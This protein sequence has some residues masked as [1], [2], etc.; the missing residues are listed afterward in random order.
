MPPTGIP[1]PKNLAP[2]PRGSNANDPK[3]AASFN[4]LQQNFLPMSLGFNIGTPTGTPGM[5]TSPGRT[6]TLQDILGGGAP[7]VGA[8]VSG[9]PGTPEQYAAAGLS[10]PGQTTNLGAYNVTPDQYTNP[11]PTPS[12]LSYLGLPNYGGMSGNNS[13]N[14]FAGLFGAQDQTNFLSGWT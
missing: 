6:F 3:L 14:G 8:T 4:N 13:D 5:T 1:L 10:A 7:S 11:T 9:S 2:V 12:P